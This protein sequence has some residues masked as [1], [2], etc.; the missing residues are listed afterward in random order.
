MARKIHHVDLS[1]KEREFLL[2]LIKSGERSARKITRAR[3]LLLADVS[4][5]DKEIAASLHSSVPTVQRTRKRFVQGGLE[6]ALS[7]QPR[8]GGRKAKRLDEKGEA[9][10]MT[11][12]Q[13]APPAGKAGP[14]SCWPTGWS[15]YTL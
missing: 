13:S 8:L 7:E 1:D 15:S 5:T 10:L 12:A 11:L 6:S 3:I 4:K 14:C 9:I 2:R